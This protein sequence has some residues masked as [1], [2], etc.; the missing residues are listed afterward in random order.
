MGPDKIGAESHER[1][2]ARPRNL[3]LDPRDLDVV[4]PCPLEYLH[5]YVIHLRTDVVRDIEGTV[6]DDRE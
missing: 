3:D 5:G 6:R 1:S 2:D 4:L